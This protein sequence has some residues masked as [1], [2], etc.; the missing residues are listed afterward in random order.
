MKINSEN[1]KLWKLDT[2]ET[3]TQRIA[4]DYNTIPKYLFWKNGNLEFDTN[5]I[6][7]NLDIEK[8]ENFKIVNILNDLE[9]HVIKT[10]NIFS[11]SDVES[12]YLNWIISFPDDKLDLIY[13]YIIYFV[14]YYK[15]HQDKLGN[16][17]PIT[18]LEIDIE[19]SAGNG[20]REYDL[21][22]PQKAYQSKLVTYDMYKNDVQDNKTKVNEL[23]AQFKQFEKI[24]ETKLSSSNFVIEKLKIM[25]TVEFEKH[26]SLM[27]LLNMGDINSK[28]AISDLEFS[29]IVICTNNFFKINNNYK[30]ILKGY[31]SE[32]FQDNIDNLVIVLRSVDTG[33]KKNKKTEFINIIFKPI[34]ENVRDVEFTKIP[35]EFDLSIG[36]KNSETINNL[37]IKI[38]K[39]IMGIFFPESSTAYKIISH[40]NSKIKGSY[41]ISDKYILREIF[42]DMIMNDNLF[43]ALLYV[44]ER[45]KV[46][47]YQYSIHCYFN[48]TKTGL[49][50]FNITNIKENNKISIQIRISH[51]D[52]KEQ[53]SFFISQMNNLFNMYFSQEQQIVSI[54]KSFGV[55]IKPNFEVPKQNED[56]Q[57]QPIKVKKNQKRQGLA[58]LVPEL[59][60]PLYSRKCGNVPRIVSQQ[61]QDKLP[62]KVQVM[63]YPLYN[64][65]NLEPSAYVCDKHKLFPYPGLRA[66]TLDNSDIFKYIPCCY[67]T[68]QTYRVG[69]PYGNYF[70]NQ[71]KY[72]KTDH[73]LYKTSRIIPN[74]AFGILPM[75]IN[76]IFNTKRYDTSVFYRYGAP[77]S[78]NSVLYCIMRALDIDTDTIADIRNELLLQSTSIAKQETFDL[79]D[80]D[81]HS[82]IKSDEYLDPKAFVK[83]LEDFF[84]ITIFIYE[85]DIDISKYDAKINKIIFT[86]N[87]FIKNNN[88]QLS[89]PYHKNNYLS[90]PLRN[91]ILFLY[92]HLGSDINLVSHP[93][94][95]TIIKY[96]KKT[97]DIQ[98]I[99]EPTDI[100]VIDTMKLMLELTFA[101]TFKYWNNNSLDLV[102]QYLDTNGQVYCLKIKHLNKP[103]FMFCEPLHPLNIKIGILDAK[104]SQNNIK[105]ARDLYTRLGFSEISDEPKYF[106]N[107]YYMKYA[108]GSI[109]N[110]ICYIPLDMYEFQTYERRETSYLT[111]SDYIYN[112]STAYILFEYVIQMLSGHE[113]KK[114]DKWFN[115]HCIVDNSLN[116]LEKIKAANI[117][118]P[119]VKN[120]DSIFKK[121]KKIC[122]QTQE[123]LDKI[124][125]NCKI[126][127]NR[128]NIPKTD[129]IHSYFNT[130]IFFKK[131]IN[132]DVVYGLDTFN[133]N[134]IE[135][136]EPG[137][138]LYNI[139]EYFQNSKIFTN[140]LINNGKFYIARCFTSLND[141]IKF[142]QHDNVDHVVYIWENN[143]FSY[144]NVEL[145]VHLII[146]PINSGTLYL[147]LNN[148]I[149]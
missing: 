107:N 40:N 60:L 111:I 77:F 106:H 116:Y 29:V 16:I 63:K 113:I 76:N 15:L 2:P 132:L 57:D 41:Y 101:K 56:S 68:D 50:S 7:I 128:Q 30:N 52:D 89:I 87:E 71:P 58:E 119:Y 118:I 17:D 142:Q 135:Q 39:F 80:N 73:I 38:E 120:F 66:N 20:G 105:I 23:L 48:T 62:K 143:N 79:S 45:L 26:L 145:N 115:D 129:I 133:F 22:I 125:F 42:L 136:F 137:K 34:K 122:F 55:D 134:Y 75:N 90:R 123:L 8:D 54:Y 114:I 43:S 146:F 94:C 32:V 93:Q 24:K 31:D 14:D 131:N 4:S 84:D 130:S 86:K 109:D 124:K 121:N 138:V 53:I 3:I 141:A 95:E 102:N 99:F 65:G 88:G 108:K 78:S 37:Q 61:E 144:Y 51:I 140:K 148:F 103:I 27:A 91:K 83:I 49:V 1:F 44:D 110:I 9:S 127:L 70:F 5:H 104:L 81:I 13:W 98:Q 85:R 33:G 46:T 64:E 82:W 67:A 47:K 6:P 74:S 92:L 139:L 96:D 35:I 28:I 97:K 25:F 147:T 72:G 12:T 18:F 112:M 126:I 11:I 36:K 10:S 59:F 117:I 19:S 21:N 149:I 69:S 100:H